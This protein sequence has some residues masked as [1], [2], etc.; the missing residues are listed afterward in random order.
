MLPLE[1]RQLVSF[2][3]TPAVHRRVGTI[4][5][6]LRYSKTL[7]AYFSMV[8]YCWY[9]FGLSEKPTQIYLRMVTASCRDYCS[10]VRMHPRNDLCRCSLYTIAAVV[11]HA[12]CSLLLA[13]SCPQFLP[14]FLP[15]LSFLF[16]PPAALI[17]KK[18]SKDSKQIESTWSQK[19]D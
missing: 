9:I 6:N 17:T 2:Y 10:C 11:K 1:A 8:R 14:Q 3:S 7:Q 19:N 15:H 13:L 16:S 18:T 4:H 5:V 12:L